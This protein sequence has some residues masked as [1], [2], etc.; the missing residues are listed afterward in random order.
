MGRKEKDLTGLKFNTWA[1]MEKDINKH[2]YLICRCATN[3]E[4]AKNK[5]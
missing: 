1:V 5:R 2:N 3:S 4:Q